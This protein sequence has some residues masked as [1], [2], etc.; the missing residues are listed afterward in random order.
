MSWVTIFHLMRDISRNKTTQKYNPL[1]NAFTLPVNENNRVVQPI[2]PNIK[3]AICGLIIST[4]L[5][6]F[7]IS[8]ISQ[9]LI[10]K[11]ALRNSAYHS[12]LCI[13]LSSTRF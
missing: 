11:P 7:I 3:G 9:Y 2:G 6:Q 4:A 8:D 12:L 13:I 5:C 10:S 1:I